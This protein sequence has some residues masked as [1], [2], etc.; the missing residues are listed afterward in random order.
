MTQFL[1]H[2]NRCYLIDLPR[3]VKAMIWTLAIRL[4]TPIR[5][6]QVERGSNK[7]W[8]YWS[9]WD[10]TVLTLDETLVRQPL[11]AVSLSKTCKTIYNDVASS[12]LFYRIND[13]DFRSADVMLRYLV[14]IT[15]ARAGAIRSISFPWKG[16]RVP[17]HS[18][19]MLA[20]CGGLRKLRVAISCS[21]G[22]PYRPL[23]H[24]DGIVDSMPPYLG[25]QLSRLRGLEELKVEFPAWHVQ[26]VAGRCVTVAV[27]NDDG[28]WTTEFGDAKA[29]VLR[30]EQALQRDINM[31][32]MDR[33]KPVAAKDV[34]A[35]Q[36][37]SGV[38]IYGA[39]RLG[40]DIKPNVVASRTRAQ[41]RSQQSLD[42]SGVMQKTITRPK[43]GK[44]G[45]LIWPVQK[46]CES[47]PLDLSDR[48][49]PVMLKIVWNNHLEQTWEQLENIVGRATLDPIY[50][51]YTSNP[52][53][54]G[55]KLA[56]AAIAE[57]VE[58]TPDQQHC[59]KGLRDA[60]RRLPTQQ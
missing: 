6:R 46:I 13:F 19:S 2:Q 47:K 25:T 21:Y 22:H 4:S 35:A 49:S 42:S 17:P 41:L 33:T 58:P 39:G 38:M 51:Y 31:V 29:N 5:P 8:P 45:D 11:A 7:F 34:G 12:H 16:Y 3:E 43:F 44:Y 1:E 26:C 27:L 9:T 37:A 20:T 54:Y 32:F 23:I 28:I 15:P 48:D 56:I 55:L 24:A 18:F 52:G 40:P 57:F 36:L 10:P 53:A 14:A 30:A 59:L 50:R 60:M